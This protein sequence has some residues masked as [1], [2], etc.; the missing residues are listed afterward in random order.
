MTDSTP[1]QAIRLHRMALSG[2]CHRVELFLS[3]L[4]LP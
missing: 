4:R 1:S 3:L 2:H